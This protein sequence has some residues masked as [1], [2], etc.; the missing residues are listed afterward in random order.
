[1]APLDGSPAHSTSKF[2]AEHAAIN[3]TATF[4]ELRGHDDEQRECDGPLQRQ[5]RQSAR[6]ARAPGGPMDR[7]SVQLLP[8]YVR[9]RAKESSENGADD[10]IRSEDCEEL[11]D[12]TEVRPDGGEPHRQEPEV[13][14]LAMEVQGQEDHF[15]GIHDR[16]EREK[17]KITAESPRRL[18]EV[19]IAKAAKTATQQGPCNGLCAAGLRAHANQQASHDKQIKIARAMDQAEV[20]ESGAAEAEPG[21]VAGT[22]PSKAM[23]GSSVLITVMPAVP[24]DARTQVLTARDPNPTK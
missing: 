12:T 7:Q 10:W 16:P 8:G 24:P 20:P 15:Q 17:K 3:G 6:V 11:G 9:Q 18:A 14:R 2:G 1:M 21:H 5:R 13:R 19:L 4:Q 22:F 23:N